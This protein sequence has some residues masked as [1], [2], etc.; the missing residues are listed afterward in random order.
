MTIESDA[1]LLDEL[2]AAGHEIATHG[3]GHRHLW[4][5][6]TAEFAEDLRRGLGV[7]GER[8]GSPILGYRAPQFSVPRD[9]PEFREH[10]RRHLAKAARQRKAEEMA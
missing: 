1:G 2:S 10:Y 4:R 3:Y 8:T 6:S 5:A 7:L 9:R